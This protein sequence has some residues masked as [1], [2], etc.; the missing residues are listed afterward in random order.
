MSLHFFKTHMYSY[1]GDVYCPPLSGRLSISSHRCRKLVSHLRGMTGG[2]G[3]LGTWF[4]WTD[5]WANAADRARVHV[6]C[7]SPTQN[8]TE[9]FIL[10]R[11]RR[12]D[13]GLSECGIA[14]WLLPLLCDLPRRD[15]G[16]W[17]SHRYL[18]LVLFQVAT[19]D[20]RAGPRRALPVWKRKVF[21]FDTP[22]SSGSTVSLTTVESQRNASQSHANYAVSK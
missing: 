3:G 8:R 15:V 5:K 13:P 10:T 1:T 9:F 12:N 18:V 20:S 4:L 16:R 22:H 17:P 6:Q 11:Y 14:T 7:V 21:C 2:R 19:R